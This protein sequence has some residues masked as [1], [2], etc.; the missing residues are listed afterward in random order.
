MKREFGILAIGAAAAAFFFRERLNGSLPATFSIETF[1]N[2]T[3]NEV[4]SILRTRASEAGIDPDWFDAI[5]HHES[6]YRLDAVN[7]AGPDA[8]Y[9]GSYGPMQMLATNVARLGYSVDQVTSDPYA[10]ADAAVALWLE[11]D[12]NTF[13]DAVAWWNSGHKHMND[14]PATSTAWTYLASAKNDLA[15]VK[16][17]PV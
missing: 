15:W 6:R 5:A 4:R 11:G 9:G 13:E 7:N 1:M 12:P 10:A 3:R 14:V 17:N 2:Y 8:K 16:E